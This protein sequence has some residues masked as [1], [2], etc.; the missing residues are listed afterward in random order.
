MKTYV[1]NM[2]WNPQRLAHMKEQLDALAIPFE[3]F[4]G[5]VGKDFK[6]KELR[7]VFSPLRSFIALRKKMTGGQLGCTLSHLAIY[8]KI[9]DAN[10]PYALIFE[11]DV[12]ID[13]RFPE[14]LA[15]VKEFLDP[16]QPQIF[17]F[18]GYGSDIDNN[19]PA[20]IRP[21]KNVWCTDGYVVTRAAAKLITKVNEPVI[22]VCDSFKRWRRWHGLQLFHVIPLTV[23]QANERYGSDIPFEKKANF[24][25]RLLC[26][27]LDWLLIKLT[28]R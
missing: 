19:G 15:K 2:D 10:D 12:D 24:L 23:R 6:G 7:K 3:K 25:L 1:V 18:S 22:V 21:E 11:D 9:I 8:H 20:E 16:D 28:G 5:I 14:M 13:G 17:M 4:S 27:P 26:W